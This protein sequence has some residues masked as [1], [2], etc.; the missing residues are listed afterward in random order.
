MKSNP[1]PIPESISKVA[2][3]RDISRFADMHLSTDDVPQQA[4]FEYWEHTCRDLIGDFEFTD[5][6]VKDFHAKF[7]MLSVDNLTIGHYSGSPHAMDRRKSHIKS[8]DNDSYL[9]IL[10]SQRRFN[11]SH[12]PYQQS[13]LGGISLLDNVQ[14]FL[15]AHPE[16]LDIINVF[17]PRTVL[18]NAIGPVKHAVG[19]S[20]D[21]AQT[22]FPIILSY[23]QSLIEHSTFLT[24]ARKARMAAVAV[25]L[26]AA[27]FGERMEQDPPQSLSGAALL[28]RAQAF[29][30][31]HIGAE[32]LSMEDVAAALNMSVRRLQEVASAE[33]ISLMDWMWER[34]LQL[35]HAKLA[36][37]ANSVMPVGLI[38]YHCG[39]VSQAHFSRRFKERFGQTPTE[40]RASIIADQSRDR[41]GV[42]LLKR[43]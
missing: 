32:G 38:A 7:S 37:V 39:F 25:E 22:T 3:M 9:V 18:E 1:A 28:Y 2:G 17:I 16:G 35:A 11:L 8:V 40:F 42:R 43:R 12:G 4:R 14:P 20:L 5:Y 27:G 13:T 19:L 24:P 15:G 21:P 26:I 34:R 23:L 36:D 29:I 33:N 6:K 30:A 31:D 10:Q 41:A